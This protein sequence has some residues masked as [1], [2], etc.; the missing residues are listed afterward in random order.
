MKREARLLLDKACDSLLLC[1]EHFNRPH[2]RGRVTT[3]LILLDHSFEMLLKAAI[4]ERGGKIKEK[5]KKETLGFDA[6]VRKGLSDGS[7]KFLVEDQAL[8]LQAING[9]RDAAQHHLLDISEGHLYIQAQAGVTLF[10][11]LLK[12]VFDQELREFLPERVLPV[13]TTP[14]TDLVSLFEHEVEEVLRLL[15]PGSRRKIE[16]EAKLRPLAV[17]DAAIRGEK[18]QPGSSE[19]RKLADK[20]VQGVHWET[21][22]PGVAAVELAPIGTGPTI[23][24]RLTKKEG[25]PIRLVKEGTPEAS[26]VGV[27][28]VDELSYYCLGAKELAEKIGESQNKVVAVVDHLRLREDPTF[29]K[30]FRVGSVRLKRYAQEAVDR[31]REELKTTPIETIWRQTLERRKARR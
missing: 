4:L 17:L 25:I 2:D 8:Q 29:Y 9:L 19:L 18:G 28:R 20:I 23:A 11:D 1:I 24:L 30:E 14:P 5:G 22:F 31:I 16:A 6:C 3:T 21:L 12:S 26:V 7:L 15:R 27:R 13:S 10:R